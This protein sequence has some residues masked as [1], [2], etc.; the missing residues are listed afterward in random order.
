MPAC[1]H[2]YTEGEQLQLWNSVARSLLRL[3]KSGMQPSHTNSLKELLA[4]HTL[5][6]VQVNSARTPND[7]AAVANQLVQTG[8]A[9]VVQ[10]KGSTILVR[11]A[12]AT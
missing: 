5:V 10:V 4:A 9:D 1:Q 7:M 8:V 3:G 12:A 6:K 11:G 2:N